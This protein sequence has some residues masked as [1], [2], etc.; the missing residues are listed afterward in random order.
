[1]PVKFVVEAD[2]AI[3]FAVDLDVISVHG[4]DLDRVDSGSCM[5]RFSLSESMLMPRIKAD[6]PV[7]TRYRG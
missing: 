7:S 4:E 3:D 6:A 2:S 1:M 5:L